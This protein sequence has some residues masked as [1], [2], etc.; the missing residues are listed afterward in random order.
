MKISW[1]LLGAGLIPM[2]CAAQTVRVGTFDKQAIVVA[3]YRSPIWADVLKA[4]MAE[5]ET[6]KKANDVRKIEEL[7]AWGG[8]QQ[9]LAHQQVTGDAPITNILEALAPAFP[10]IA[11]KAQVTMI[12]PDLPYANGTVQKVDV[13]DPL[14]EWLKADAATRKTVEDLRKQR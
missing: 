13:T 14:L 11:E 3:F 2:V 7:N 12:V 4:K 9:E 10:A 5:M 1:I 8:K 6:A